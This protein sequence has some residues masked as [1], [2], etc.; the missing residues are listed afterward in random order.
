MPENSIELVYINNMVRDTIGFVEY[1]ESN[2]LPEELWTSIFKLLE[3]S[4][5]P[6]DEKTIY[7]FYAA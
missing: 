7:S 6:F 5:H 2:H 4:N 1:N 3:K